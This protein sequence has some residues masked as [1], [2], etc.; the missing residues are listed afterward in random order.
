M[1]AFGLTIG[2]LICLD[3]AS[4]SAVVSAVKRPPRLDLLLICSYSRWI[5]R[6]KKLA[7]TTSAVMPG[8]AVIVNRSENE[9]SSSAY[10]FECGSEKAVTPKRPRP[11]IHGGGVIHTYDIDRSKL[12]EM[13]VDQTYKCNESLQWL[14][15]V[16]LEMD[17]R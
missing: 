1:R 14:Y 16:E 12:W 4:F 3:L 13:Q 10:L 6:L 8:I 11:P 17:V 15:G 2:I 7:E 9:E 5:E